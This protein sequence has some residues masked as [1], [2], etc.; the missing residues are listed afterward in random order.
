MRIWKETL[1]QIIESKKKTVGEVGESLGKTRSY[2]PK[3]LMQ[4]YD[5]FKTIE[6]L[7]L[8]SILGCTKEELGAIPAKGENRKDEDGDVL[9]ELQMLSANIASG[10]MMLRKDMPT[11]DKIDGLHEMIRDGFKML[12]TDIR[13][14][15]ASMEKCWG[16]T[17]E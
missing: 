14:L 10:L 11:N 5:E 15:I 4:G 3:R 8:C 7:A 2:L 1:Y 16:E 12:H 9:T 13:A 17:K 6:A